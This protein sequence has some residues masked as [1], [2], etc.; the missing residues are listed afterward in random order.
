MS[1]KQGLIA[2]D[3][4]GTLTDGSRLIPDQVVNYLHGLHDSGWQIAL[5]TG[6]MYS[7]AKRAIANMNFPYYL[8]IQNGADI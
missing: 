1:K 7:F 6:R 3:I 8:G 2:L 5:I 4:D